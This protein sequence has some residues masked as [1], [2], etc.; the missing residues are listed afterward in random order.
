MKKPLLLD[1]FCGAGG[2]A[3][4]YNRAGFEVVGVDLAPQ[5]HYPYEF[6]QADALE[7]LDTLLSGQ[8]WQGYR[9]ADFAAIHA[10]PPCQEYSSSRHFRSVTNTNYTRPMLIA[11]ILRRLR[12][13]GVPWILENVSGALDALPNAI[14]LCG[15]S[16][17]L[18]ILRH[19]LF[20][21]SEMLFAPSHCKHPDAFYNVAGGKVRAIGAHR[22]N[23][24]YTTKRGTIQY[25]EGY[26]RKEVGQAAMGIDWMTLK[27]MSEAIPPAY[28]EYLGAQL[29]A[30]VERS[31]A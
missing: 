20:L 3:V 30:I 12:A 24:A 31:A 1:L 17:G 23:K 22:T 28:T 7:V 16:F 6:H 29:L 13:S 10:S 25:R 21:S 2:C 11:P 8:E 4:G 18:P 14:E 26:A 15:A 5:K 19:R 9:L 27:E